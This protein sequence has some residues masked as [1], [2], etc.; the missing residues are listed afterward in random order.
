MHY[1]EKGITLDR[2]EG[3]LY[4]KQDKNTGKLIKEGFKSFYA[5]SWMTGDEDIVIISNLYLQQIIDNARMISMSV[6]CFKE[7]GKVLQNIY[8]DGYCANEIYEEYELDENTKNY[9]QKHSSIVKEQKLI[10][11]IGIKREIFDGEYRIPFYPEYPQTYL[12]SN[13][14]LLDYMSNNITDELKNVVMHY[15]DK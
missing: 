13:Y 1:F 5:E 3:S 12:T 9:I 15:N 11:I 4:I 6:I 8:V 14:F 7:N 10:P 2:P